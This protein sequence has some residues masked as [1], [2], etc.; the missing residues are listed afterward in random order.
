[1]SSGTTTL[2]K[3]LQ[4]LFGALCDGLR[5]EVR[6]R[7]V[8]RKT[9]PNYFEVSLARVREREKASS[10]YFQL[11]SSGYIVQP[12]SYYAKGDEALTP[13]FR[14]WL[15]SV[16]C[17]LF[18][19]L[20]VVAW[21]ADEQYY[22]QSVLRDVAKLRDVGN[23]DNSNLPNGLLVIGFSRLNDHLRA[24]GLLYNAFQDLSV[25]VVT[26]CGSYQPVDVKPVDL[27]HMDPKTNYAM[28]GLW[29]RKPPDNPGS[30]DN[31]RS[32]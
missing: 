19:E 17:F 11:R 26:K 7:M 32:S 29:V 4:V 18:L 20:K 16:P 6:Y 10:L 12:E 5:Q 31:P 30:V 21:G 13:D 9:V 27:H 22:F 14:I 3:E 25:K 1:M 2:D 23:A 15:P 8:A 24:N 28:V